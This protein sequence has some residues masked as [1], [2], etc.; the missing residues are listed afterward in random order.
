MNPFLRK[1]NYKN[2]IIAQ[3]AP[4]DIK[5]K[6]RDMGYNIIDSIKAD[7]LYDSIA[8][9]PDIV[10]HPLDDRNLFIAKNLFE[11][12]KQI[13][14]KYNLNLIPT[15]REFR[16]EYPNYIGLNIGRVRDYYI[17]SKNT[18]SRAIEEFK[19]KG[20]KNIFVKQG[21]SKCS[22]LNIKENIII[23]SDRGIEKELKKYDEIEVY[24]IDPRGI[25][26]EGMEY[27]F[28][29]GCGIMI[30]EKDLILTGHTNNM[31]DSKLFHQILNKYEINVNYLSD[32]G[33]IDIGG[34]IVF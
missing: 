17:H 15:N 9:H 33:I 21:Y 1:E 7:F 30:S 10:L 13:L 26:L 24:Y 11:E 2:I 3:N 29:G 27:G 31:R 19:K 4:Y 25:E 28:I 6:L 18:D 14:G 5:A 16:S 32:K 22:T 8:Y 12:Y 20:I 23:T 34:F